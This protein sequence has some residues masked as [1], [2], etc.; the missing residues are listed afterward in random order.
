MEYRTLGRTGLSVSVAG[1]GTGG[2][3]QLGQSTGRTE[4]ESHRVVRTALDLGINI[5]DSSSGYRDSE[6]LLGGALEGVP[7][8]RY[9]LATKFQPGR[10]AELKEAG[11]LT[12]QLDRSLRRMGVDYVDVFQYHGVPRGMYRQTIERFHELAL[13]AQQAGKVRFIGI[14]E[15]VAEDP[16]HEMLPMALEDDLFDTIMI[17]YGILNQS[18]AQVV[19]PMA[20]KRQ[21]GVLVMAAVRTSLRNPEEAVA[22]LNGFIDEGRLDL[23]RP[24][25]A[26]PLGLGRTGDPVPGLRRA[27]YQFAAAHEAV[28]TVLIGTGNAEHLKAN[29]AD[30]LAPPMTEAQLAY[31]HKTYR[32]LDWT[33]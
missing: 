8:D 4:A 1:L 31:L 6:A 11:S 24:T 14:T 21:V 22:C 19:L 7:R 18:G 9:I 25:L 2:A 20:Q 23:P 27:A 10:G 5:F 3:S 33:R 30:L 29:V 16:H 32:H 12:E 13:R 26:D 17:K 28:S 15:T